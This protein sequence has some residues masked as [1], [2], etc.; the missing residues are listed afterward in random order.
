[1]AVEEFCAKVSVVPGGNVPTWSAVF[2]VVKRVTY[3]ARAA[4]TRISA[5]TT[6]AADHLQP[7]EAD[8]HPIPTLPDLARTPPLIRWM[9]TFRS[10]RRL[11]AQPP[12]W[13]DGV[14]T[15][16]LDWAGA[17]HILGYG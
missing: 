10:S 6:H 9:V 17:I 15:P 5:T 7:R 16:E 11:L 8:D 1:M 3:C 12:R 2:V 14:E 13:V 4:V